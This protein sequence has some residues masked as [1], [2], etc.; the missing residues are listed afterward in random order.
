MEIYRRYNVV[1]TFRPTHVGQ[2]LLTFTTL[3]QR[4]Y[5]VYT[6]DITLLQRLQLWYDVDRSFNMKMC[7]TTFVKRFS[8]CII[9]VRIQ[10]WTYSVHK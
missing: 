8:L 9:L 6:I 7:E 4:F 5:N 10:R 2:M 3:V 1:T